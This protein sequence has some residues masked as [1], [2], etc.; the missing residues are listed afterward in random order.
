MVYR[1]FDFDV[2]E[3]YLGW[4]C[5]IVHADQEIRSY[6]SLMSDLHNRKFYSLVPHDEN[7]ASD[8]L[9]LRE[10]Y[11][12]EVNYPHF[13]HIDGDCSVLEMLIALA[14]RM[15]F[16][17]SDPK[18]MSDTGRVTYWF[19][20]LIDNLGLIEFSDD[21]YLAIGGPLEVNLALDRLLNRRYAED[22]YGGLFPLE[23][24]RC[25]Q[26]DVE[27]WYQMAAY[28]AEREQ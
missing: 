5:E 1:E 17:T 8:G 4:M 19:W 16:E 24:P 11:L 22:G 28:L 6:F 21:C 18:N 15:D 7:R 12:T 27:I 3:D 20:E 13:V 10:E 26:R 14:K 23:N 2:D 25:D 9:K